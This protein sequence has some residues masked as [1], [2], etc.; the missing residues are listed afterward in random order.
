M[1]NAPRYC[2][3]LVALL[4]DAAHAST[5]HAGAGAGMAVEDALVLAELISDPRISS[6][7]DLPAV[8][9]A[10]DEARRPRTQRLVQ[11]SRESGM[12]FQLRKPGTE[13]DLDKIKADLNDRQKW[14]WEIDLDDHVNDARAGLSNFLRESWE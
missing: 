12:L 8:F 2:S 4:G 13:D 1:P 7:L 3:K 14:I 10:Y 11:H 9:A 6:V 5:S